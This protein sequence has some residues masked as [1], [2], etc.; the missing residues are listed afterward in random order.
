M[1]APCIMSDDF[2]RRRKIFELINLKVWVDK[3]S[4][5]V[6]FKIP[7]IPVRERQIVS[8]QL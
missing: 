6:D 2:E 1:S 8:T 5:S 4:F 7:S 3:D